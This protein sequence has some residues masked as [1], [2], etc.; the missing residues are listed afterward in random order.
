MKRFLS[1]GSNKGDHGQDPDPTTDNAKGKDG[2][3]LTSDGCLMI[4]GGS[5]AY[6][7]KHHQKVTRHEVY[8]TEPAT[9][10]F[11]WWSESTITFDQT[12]H[13][14]SVPQ[15]GRYPLVVDPIVGTK[16]LTKVLVDRGSGLNIMYAET[17]DAMG[18]D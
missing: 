12:D 9:P 8:T 2:S 14:E 13:P 10:A 6:D 5:V 17:L 4:F 16:R 18:V 7:S 1:S 3:F 15:P 11:L